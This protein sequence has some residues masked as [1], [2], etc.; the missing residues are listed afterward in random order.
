M[1]NWLIIIFIAGVSVA[2]KVVAQELQMTEISSLE[3]IQG[4]FQISDELIPMNDLGMENID[5]VI[6]NLFIRHFLLFSYIISINIIVCKEK[7]WINH[8]F[9]TSYSKRICSCSG[10]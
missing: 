10:T 2:N 1:K 6:K 9:S 7:R 3:Q 8:L 5:H 4:E